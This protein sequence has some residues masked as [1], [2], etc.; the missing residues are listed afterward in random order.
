MLHFDHY[1]QRPKLLLTQSAPHAHGTVEALAGI[2]V[3][4]LVEPMLVTRD[5][6]IDRDEAADAAALV[7]TSANG[8]E[9]FLRQ[10]RIGDNV[11]LYA[12][13]PQTAACLA[14]RGYRDA[15]VGE[16]DADSL[17]RLIF[18]TW[19]PTDGK[20]VHVS[21]KH[22]KS[23][24]A[25][26]LRSWG[27]KASRTISYVADQ[28]EDVSET[29]L[30]AFRSGSLL[31]VVFVS[32]RAAKAFCAI[33]EVQDVLGHKPCRFAFCLSEYIAGGIDER[34]FSDI[35]WSVRPTREAL[36]HRIETC[37]ADLQLNAPQHIQPATT[38]N[39]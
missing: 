12:V 24:I 37:L 23:D 38:E 4:Y 25:L 8:V 27:Y 15:V 11:R 35:L 7:F 3:S 30:D 21:G 6:P 26:E 28:V 18:S 20:I 1:A 32:R 36:V 29:T 13:G 10:G 14:Q 31:G 39:V 22:V 19:R 9:A 17:L 33:A 34:L 2:G 5:L 16:G